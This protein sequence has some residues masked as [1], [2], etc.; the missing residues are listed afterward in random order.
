MRAFLAIAATAVIAAAP[1]AG[2][3]AQDYGRARQGTSFFS[4]QPIPDLIGIKD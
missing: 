4:P 1:T 2:A 3:F